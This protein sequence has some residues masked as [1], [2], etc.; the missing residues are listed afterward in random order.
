M[1]WT[2]VNEL[3]RKT[4]CFGLRKVQGKHNKIKFVKLV[5]DCGKSYAPAMNEIK[6]LGKVMTDT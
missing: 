6:Y 1:D 4:L 3:D 2:I 5:K